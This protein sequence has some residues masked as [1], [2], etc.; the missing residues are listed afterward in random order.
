MAA[1]VDGY[2]DHLAAEKGLARNSLEAYG[3]DLRL[4]LEVMRG[5]GRSEPSQVDRGDLIAFLE[6]LE[7]RGMAPSSRARILSAV[8]G[9]FRF[10][11][12]E[13]RL[14]SSPVRD[15]R[16]GRRRRPIPKQLATTEIESLLAVSAGDAP[17]LLRDR[18][19]LELLYG[20]G[21]RVSELVGLTAAELHLEQGYLAVVGKGSKERAVPVGRAAQEAL[22]EYLERGRPAL[23]PLGRARALFLSQAG[24][25]LSRQGFWK[26]L[27]GLADAAG[28]ER[29]SPHVLRHSFATHLLEGGADLRSVQLLLGHA[30]ITT[31]QIYTHVATGRLSEVHRRHHPRA[32]MRVTR[33]PSR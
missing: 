23:D 28:L 15:L 14:E 1:A 22:R 21:L 2:L 9:L 32:Q 25:R 12:R 3:H 33:E 29:V 7:R 31:T 13:G 8:R 6:S 30:D 26:R 11:V 20:C 18:A 17:L 5:R 4:L 10:L 24:K 27:R 16:A 19:M